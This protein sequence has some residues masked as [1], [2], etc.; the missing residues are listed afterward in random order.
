MYFSAV[1]VAGDMTFCEWAAGLAPAGGEQQLAGSG[2]A[3]IRNIK[4]SLPYDVP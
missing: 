3:M 4:D 2:A 1:C